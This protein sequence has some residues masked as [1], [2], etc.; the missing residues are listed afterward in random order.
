MDCSLMIYPTN[1]SLPVIG[2]ISKTPPKGDVTVVNRTVLYDY[3]L[4]DVYSTVK[5]DNINVNG[6]N[7][8]APIP[9]QTPIRINLQISTA[10][11][12]D[13]FVLHLTSIWKI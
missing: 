2:I 5:P 7:M 10:E 12:L 4:I 6:L 8:F 3:N 1:T 11:N 13:G 9:T